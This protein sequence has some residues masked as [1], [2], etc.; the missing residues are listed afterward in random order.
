MSGEKVIEDKD[1]H[2]SFG[3]TRV[4]RGVSMLSPALPALRPALSGPYRPLP[5][6]CSRRRTH[7]GG[8]PQTTRKAR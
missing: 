5:R 6:R 7:P 8:T 1:L 4:V 3:H 2:K